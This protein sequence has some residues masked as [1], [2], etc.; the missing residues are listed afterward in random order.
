[1]RLRLKTFELI[2][3][4]R[5]HGGNTRGKIAA[6]AFLR[7]RSR[8]GRHGR[9]PTTTG[10]RQRVCSRTATTVPGRPSIGLG[11]GRVGLHARHNTKPS[12]PLVNAWRRLVTL[13]SSARAD[14]LRGAGQPSPNTDGQFRASILEGPVGRGPRGTMVWRMRRRSVRD[15]IRRLPAREVAF[16]PIGRLVLATRRS[17]IHGT[18][19]RRRCAL[20][21]NDAV[22]AVPGD[23]IIRRDAVLD[24][25]DERL[26]RIRLVAP[27]PPPQCP[28]PGN[29]NS[30]T[31]SRA[32]LMLPR[33]VVSTTCW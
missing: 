19:R 30:R 6:P 31:F 10:L 18:L 29:M 2:R 33:N 25:R 20:V 3:T 13:S 15:T 8:P 4:T 14:P 12:R 1:M 11:K 28:M 7:S 16:H 23:Q 17:D 32:A 26:Q 27:G 5:T 24:P 21:V 9:R 22:G